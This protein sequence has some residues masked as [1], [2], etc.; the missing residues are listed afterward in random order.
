MH[1]YP[2]PGPKEWVG[3]EYYFGFLGSIA[4][5]LTDTIT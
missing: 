3:K 4:Y 2:F 1:T 5:T